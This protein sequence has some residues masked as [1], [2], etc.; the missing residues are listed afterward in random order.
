MRV[1]WVTIVGLLACNHETPVE[2]GPVA[3]P[4]GAIKDVRLGMSVAGVERV[5]P[6]LPF[7]TTHDVADH[8]DHDGSYSVF[9]TG[10]RVQRIEA[11]PFRRPVADLWKSWGDKGVSDAGGRHHYFFDPAAKI[12]AQVYVVP[13]GTFAV[14]YQTYEP[15]ASV[16]AG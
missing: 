15:L 16:I 13:E 9:F 7:N 12:R 1:R 6:S 8:F 11:Q 2:I 10:G 4:F 5:A 3:Q 14:H